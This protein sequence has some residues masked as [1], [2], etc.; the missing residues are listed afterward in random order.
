[1]WRR[2]VLAT[3]LLA[4]LAISAAA[5]P[6][7]LHVFP[8]SDTLAEN[9]LRLSIAFDRPVSG[10][11]LTRMSL[12]S[13]A[14]IEVSAPFLPQELWSPDGTILTILFHPG[15][16]KSGLIANER[17]GRALTAGIPV[18]LTLDG[19]ILRRWNVAAADE[20]PPAPAHW[21][22]GE[23]RHRGREPLQLTLDAPID[24]RAGDY[25]AVRDA[26]GNRVAGVG[27]LALGER[28]WTFVPAAPWRPGH[29]QVVVHPSL[30][31][32]AGNRAGQRFED[33][34]LAGASAPS[35][36]GVGFDVP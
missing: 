31:D 20:D 6:Q 30:E 10:P 1:M 29:Y 32:S 9:T 13:E 8:S 18:V 16:V 7:V 2:S 34:G 12:R 4:C 15:R 35:V 5:E 27:T 3:A 19:G 33:V 28:H 11:V 22:V 23:I 36:L 14:G 26:Q 24:A 17:M 25:I 21:T